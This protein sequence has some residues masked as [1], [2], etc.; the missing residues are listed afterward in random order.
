MSDDEPDDA[1]SAAT[2]R[3]LDVNLLRQALPYMRKHRKRTVVVKFGGH[4]VQDRTALENLASD[5]ALLHNVGMRICI[6]HG[7]GPQATSLQE[8][9]GLEPQFV[10]GRRITDEATLEVAKMVFAGKINLEVLGA[11][12]NEDLAAVGLSG[13]SG[14]LV[15]ARRRDP[16]AITDPATGATRTVDYGHVGDIESVDT[17]LLRILMENGYIPVVSSLGAD[18]RGNILNINA[19]TVAVEMAV[20]LKADKFLNMTQ[21]PGVLR[22]IDDPSSLVGDLSAEQAEGLVKEGVVKGG[23]VPKVHSCVQAVRRGVPRAHILNGLEPHAM[24]LEL[25][26]VRG[27]GTMITLDPVAPGADAI[28]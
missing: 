25:F 22:D 9:L 10:E 2:E 1:A 27:A 7:G 12:R 8:R 19:D 23:M 14:D 24:L 16:R 6:V 26:T 4:L 17:E 5:I 18:K 15:Q 13:V 11:L 3:D 21:V 20:D 28:A